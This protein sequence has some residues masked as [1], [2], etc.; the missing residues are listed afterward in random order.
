VSLAPPPPPDSPPDSKRNPRRDSAP[1]LSEVER[2]ISVLQGRHPEHERIRREDAEAKAVRAAEHAAAHRVASRMELQR[3]LKLGAVG[4]VVLVALV[5]IAGSVRKE[6][7]RTE[8]LQHAAEPF[9]SK[10]WTLVETSSRGDPTK[11][12]AD[13]DAGCYIAAG[14][15]PGTLK[16]AYPGGFI[17]GEGSVLTCL[18][19]PGKVTVTSEKKAEGLVLLKN[20]AAS[21]G[22]SRAFYFLPVKVGALG[23]SDQGCAEASLDAWIDAKK[24]LTLTPDTKWLDAPE[25]KPLKEAGFTAAGSVRGD[26]PFGIIEVPANTCMLLVDE[27]GTDKT[28]VRLKG[29]GQAISAT[30]TSA[31]CTSTP[32][33]AAV[34]HE[35]RP[36]DTAH[37]LRILFA[38]AARVGG[39]WGVRD[40]A[41]KSNLRIAEMTVPPTDR[42]WI[43]KQ[44]L[45]ASAIPE[46]L[47]SVGIEENKEARIAVLSVET[48]GALVPD[49]AEGVFSFCDPPL[50][51]SIASLCVFSGPQRWRIEGD[52]AA[53]LARA[54]TPFWLFGLQNVA[55]PAAMKRETQ[56]I[57][58][59][60]ALRRDGFE[61]TT[62]EAITETEKGAEV[63]G[64]ANEDAIVAVTLAPADPWAI[65][66]SDSPDSTWS[67]DDDLPRIVPIKP[68]ERVQVVAP[69]KIKLPAK[70][71][72]RT[73]VFRR[74]I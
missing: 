59:A 45:V 70:Q 5:V 63:L 19:E 74:H 16:L 58:L 1:E 8:A 6:S 28:S 22:G 31:W 13:V 27:T 57:T 2:A 42:D 10:G 14:A 46:S 50:N 34:Q 40:A 56:M 20:E 54:K 71:L 38:S 53:G 15:K 18:C 9:S 12:D 65:P 24:W 17:E 43:A 73:V 68:L 66:L 4:A 69:A 72:R 61:P 36:G 44:L 47:I 33:V 49:A 29:G 62:I 55:E 25:R 48:A 37:E 32:T 64:R 7:K 21:V 52:K 11:L 51:Q 23:Y 35:A 67:L 41:E 30:G 60:R 26:S 3:R 39:L